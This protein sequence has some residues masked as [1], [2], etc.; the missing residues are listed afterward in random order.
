M[1]D[2]NFYNEPHL[3]QY[4]NFLDS[5]PKVN[6]LPLSLKYD[7]LEPIFEYQELSYSVIE[8]EERRKMLISLS[9]ISSFENADTVLFL[10]GS[11]ARFLSYL[12]VLFPKIKFEIFSDGILDRKVV[13]DFNIRKFP[14]QFNPNYYKKK[15]ENLVIISFERDIDLNQKTF[16][17]L[18]PLGMI[19]DFEIKKDVSFLDGTLLFQPWSNPNSTCLSLIPNTQKKHYSF[20]RIK[21]NVFSFNVKKRAEYY[22]SDVKANGLDHCFDCS[23]EVNIWQL[24][25]LSQNVPP[26][27]SRISREINYLT[28]F[29]SDGKLS[30]IP[31]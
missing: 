11:P 23:A 7:D 1:A 4:R 15:S 6:Y 12:T 30:S 3:Q 21:N 19:L 28:R 13:N 17:L 29:L 25:F 2:I 27:E 31:V 9:F 5:E 18:N 14:K 26:E 22:K 10:D 16:L 24:Y 20:E 8:W